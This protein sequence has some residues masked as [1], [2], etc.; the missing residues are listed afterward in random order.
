MKK[1]D[2]NPNYW[3][4]NLFYFNKDDKRIFVPKQIDWMGITLN[5]GNPKTYLALVLIIS[6]FSFILYIIE[7]KN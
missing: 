1:T 6:F 4:W 2:K 5:F 3:K 7:S